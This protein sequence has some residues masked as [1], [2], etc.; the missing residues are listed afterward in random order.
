MQIQVKQ[1]TSV[2]EIR[3]NTGRLKA[4]EPAAR[5]RAEHIADAVA[6]VRIPC[7][8]QQRRANHTQP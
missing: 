7:A 8:G 6:L 1:E 3:G 4:T 2:A 5:G